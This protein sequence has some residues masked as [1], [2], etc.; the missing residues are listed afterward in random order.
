M[1]HSTS[2]V[3]VAIAVV[4][5]HIAVVDVSFATTC[6]FSPQLVCTFLWSFISDFTIVDTFASSCCISFT[7]IRIPLCFM[8]LDSFDLRALTPFV[9]SV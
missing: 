4:A 7:L 2:I 8:K 5:F 6:C 1:T 9:T 3:V